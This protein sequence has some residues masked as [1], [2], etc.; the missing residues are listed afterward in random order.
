[1][2]HP[3]RDL[4]NA[5]AERAEKDLAGFRSSAF[6]VVT[7]S[8]AIITVLLTVL[9]FGAAQFGSEDDPALVSGT[10]LG[11]F[12]LALI[13]LFGAALCAVVA[14]HPRELEHR[15]SSAA[16][17]AITS[18][19][20]WRGVDEELPGEPG[21]TPEQ[22]AAEVTAKYVGSVRAVAEKASFWLS[23]AIKVQ[24]AGLFAVLVGG[25]VALDDILS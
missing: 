7:A 19:A 11:V 1:M 22:E 24:A 6:T 18:S 21:S 17:V 5:E 16:L 23:L 3:F 14:N 10:A 12:S 15:P 4:V 9:T 13:L 25:L 2:T 20:Q 8:G